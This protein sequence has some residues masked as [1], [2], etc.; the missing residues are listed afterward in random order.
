ME[1]RLDSS[2]G[3]GEVDPVADGDEE[4]AAAELAAHDG[5][6]D[7]ALVLERRPVAGLGAGLGETSEQ[8]RFGDADGRQ[9][10][11]HAEVAGEAEAP[12]MRPALAVDH[13]KIGRRGQHRQGRGGGRNLAKREQARAVGKR[14]R[15]GR[16][17]TLR[18]FQGPG[19]EGGSGGEGGLAVPGEMNVDARDP[20][21]GEALGW[22]FDHVV[23]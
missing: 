1:G 12:G 8:P 19:I 5:T 11:Q 16:L 3:G 20:A 21:D 23:P 6:D 7:L 14:R 15:P 17:G 9:V 4:R 22:H 18:E 10:E 13:E 2:D